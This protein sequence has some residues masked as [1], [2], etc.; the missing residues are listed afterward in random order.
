MLDPASSH[1]VL[2]ALMSG[3]MAAH[4]I[5]QVVCYEAS[6]SAAAQRYSDWI[7]RWFDHDVAGLLALYGRLPKP[8]G[9]VRERGSISGPHVFP[10]VAGEKLEPTLRVTP[11]V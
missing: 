5:A 3:M 1:G 4:L 11:D 6:E 8:P 2:K 9:W 10:P 7:L